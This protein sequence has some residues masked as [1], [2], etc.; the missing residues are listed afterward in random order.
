M[1]IELLGDVVSNK[2]H[3]PFVIFVLLVCAWVACKNL[4]RLCGEIAEMP[5]IVGQRK[6]QGEK[7]SEA[8]DR[9]WT[10]L[11]EVKG[12]YRWKLFGWTFVLMCDVYV[13]APDLGI[14]DISNIPFRDALFIV[15][16]IA[17]LTWILLGIVIVE[18][19]RQND[20]A[21]PY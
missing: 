18:L 16:S 8:I 3:Q 5:R 21:P 9:I 15:T 17:V 19:L 10:E 11:S 6:S 4:L 2:P 12:F 20:A 1:V 13:A 14:A 7:K